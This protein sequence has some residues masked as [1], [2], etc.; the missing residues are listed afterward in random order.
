MADV[1]QFKPAPDPV[2]GT[3][4]GGDHGGMSTPTRT[5]FESRLETVEAR[6][7]SRVIRIESKIDSYL[8]VAAERDKRIDLLAESAAKSA[9]RAS[10]LKGHFWGAVVT[11]IL[12]V[13]AI[14]IS[15]FYAT[16][17]SNIAI[18]QTTLSAFQQGQQ[19]PLKK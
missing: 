12:S 15:S 3:G 1:R 6:M 5:E 9:E 8:A 2:D 10:T 13:A 18:V 19:T 7:D 14:A 11:I 16:Q 17:S 4:G